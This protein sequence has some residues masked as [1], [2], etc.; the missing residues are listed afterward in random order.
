M[1]KEI[2]PCF[3]CGR[4]C[5]TE[6]HDIP[7]YEGLYQ[8]TADGNVVSIMF[9][10]NRIK[11][12]QYRVLKPFDNGR[13]YLTVNLR[14]NGVR[15]PHYVHRIVAD[16]FISNPDGYKVVN[17]KDGDTHNNAVENLEWCTQKYNVNYSK[18]KMRKPK[19][20]CRQTNTGHKYIS[21]LNN[22]GKQVYRVCIRQKGICK[23]FKT[24]E[25]AISYREEVI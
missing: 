2:K 23:Q 10:N 17:H 19:S 21:L 20:K 9:R 16:V 13:G 6:R 4:Y 11:K 22:H 12:E 8:V 5:Y 24:L 25:D 7:G 3:N 15:K 18:E 14:K 1:P